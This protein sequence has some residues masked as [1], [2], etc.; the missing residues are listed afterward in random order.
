MGAELAEPVPTFVKYQLWPGL[1]PNNWFMS[2]ALTLFN[3]AFKAVLVFQIPQALP[4]A[5]VVVTV[6]A[7]LSEKML[8]GI[9]GIG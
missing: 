3:A 1:W 5:V 7:E 4:S 2:I 9:V 6:F 8:F